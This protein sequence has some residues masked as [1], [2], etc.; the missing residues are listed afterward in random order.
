[1]TLGRFTC[2]IE[3][4]LAKGR[5]QLV[6]FSL[7]LI[8]C[9]IRF[10]TEFEAPC[11]EDRTQPVRCPNLFDL[12]KKKIILFSSVKKWKY[13]ELEKEIF[14]IYCGINN[15]RHKQEF[16]CRG[17]LLFPNSLLQLIAAENSSSIWSVDLQLRKLPKHFSIATQNAIFWLFFFIIATK[18]C[19][20]SFF[21]YKLHS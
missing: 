1:M 15:R 6:P 13:Y 14:R 8:W 16:H 9:Q 19:M 11:L 7:G 5:Q 2:T 20:F 4:N 10:L 3:S 18:L 21:C 12:R 17:T